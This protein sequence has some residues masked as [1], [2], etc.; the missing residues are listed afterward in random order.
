VA[1]V[2]RAVNVHLGFRYDRSIRARIARNWFG[3][4]VAC[5]ERGDREGARRYGW[6]CLSR[7]P[8]TMLWPYRLRLLLPPL[9]ADRVATGAARPPATPTSE[10]AR[11]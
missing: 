1:A 4:A 11:A 8:L 5:A 10:T 3:V 7:A 9:R 6:R 2:Y